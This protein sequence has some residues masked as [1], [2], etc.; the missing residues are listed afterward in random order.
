[1]TTVLL[2]PGSIA[3]AMLRLGAG[4][5][6]WR[7]VLLARAAVRARPA[8]LRVAAAALATSP[9]F[10]WSAT[11]TLRGFV[12]HLS[13]GD[14]RGWLFSDPAT[15]ESQLRFVQ[16]RVPS[17]FVWAGLIVAALGAWTLARRAPAL[18][19]MTALFAIAGIVFATG[20]KVMD[21]ETYLL[22]TILAGGIA[23]RQ[24]SR[25]SSSA[26]ARAPCSSR[27]PGSW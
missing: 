9:R 8:A 11:H 27:A 12:H 22:V 26:S 18:A 13:G 17:D 20:Y 24:G 4:R 2:A 23:S 14:Y 21:V 5:K 19:T 3:A 16:W 1:M 7:S 15:F 10:D 25:G 6:L